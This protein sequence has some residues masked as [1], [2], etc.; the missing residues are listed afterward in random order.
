LREGRLRRLTDP[1]AVELVKR[2]GE[3]GRV[4]RDPREFLDLLMPV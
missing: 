3:T 1:D 4:R 2:E